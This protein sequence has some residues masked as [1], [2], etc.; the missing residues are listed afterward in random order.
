MKVKLC[1]FTE[2]NSVQVAISKNP[3][4]LGFVF[5]K[6][7]PRYISPKDA[8]LISKE[9][10]KNI[11]K[12]AVVVDF[13]IDELEE[14]LKE[15]RTDF[16]QFHGD[17]S[18]E[19]L[20][21]FHKKFPQIKII[22]AFKIEQIKDLEQINFFEDCAD[23]FLF[24]AKVAGEI[25]GSGKQF[26]WE[27]LKNLKTKKDWFLSGGLN[28]NN[29][30]RALEISAAKMIDISSGIEEMRGEKSPKLIKEFME[31]ITNL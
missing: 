20:K 13:E 21:N 4:F 28:V 25:G 16:V 23:F 8:E 27:I 2:E 15:F 11:S 10:P 7:S 3:D 5:Y 18:A 24:D 17:E 6:K 19:F 26:D 1:G 30:A 12:V 14:I 29:I 9:V 31:K 22:K